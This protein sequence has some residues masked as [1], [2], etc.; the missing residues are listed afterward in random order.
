MVCRISSYEVYRLRW[1]EH[2]TVL[3]LSV[4]MS[5]GS[6]G[7]GEASMSGDD[8]ATS[9]YVGRIFR[10]LL[11]DRPAGELLLAIDTLGTLA[12][13]A[14][15]FC[16]ATAASALEQALWDIQGKL[17]GVPVH[18]LIGGARRTSIPLYG[19]INRT[20]GQRGPAEFA[21]SAS[22]AE[23]YGLSAVKCAPFDEVLP[24]ELE[25]GPEGLGAGLARLQAVRAAISPGCLLMV[26]CH[27]RLGLAR[28][29]SIAPALEALSVKWL[30]EPILTNE[31]M[32]RVIRRRSPRA[33]S[34]SGVDVDGAVEFA[35]TSRIPLAGGEFEVGLR[36]FVELMQSRALTFVMPDVKYCGG[37]WVATGVAIVA[38]ALGV[39]VSPHNPAGPVATLASAQVAAVSPTL[40]SLE[41]AWGELLP[42]RGL[43][44]PPLKVISGRLELPEGPGLGAELVS[45]T[46]ERLRI[47]LVGRV[48]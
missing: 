39:K 31:E 36:R 4:R 42:E 18:V 22:E 38:A 32:W 30:E 46:V 20:P 6:G 19:N 28:A 35:G 3:L 10:D 40:D 45:G 29:Q 11:V 33:G 37:I 27:G 21:R 5:D 9:E 17:L 13:E 16:E 23:A 47:P 43:V 8:V 26:D 41:I 34:A 12:A 48:P 7:I 2:T 24:P 44:D 14:V 15:A 25:P 1:G